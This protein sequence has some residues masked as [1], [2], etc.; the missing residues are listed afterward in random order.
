VFGR[1]GIGG[2]QPAEVDRMLDAERDKLASELAWLKTHHEAL[3]RADAM[4]DERF[5]GLAH[6]K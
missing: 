1:K 4:L 6:G 2:P 3:A 5:E